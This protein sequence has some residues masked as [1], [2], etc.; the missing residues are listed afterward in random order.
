MLAV[1]SPEA[2]KPVVV[3]AF[4]NPISDPGEVY[5]GCYGRASIDFYGY[6]KQGNKGVSAGLLSV[7]KLHDGDSLGGARGS[8]DDFNDGYVDAGMNDDFLR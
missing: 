2:I 6:S 1:S 4:C 8:A 5:S 7:Q 3:D